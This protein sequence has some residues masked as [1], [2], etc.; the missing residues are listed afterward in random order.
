MRVINL[1]AAT[2]FLSNS[3]RCLLFL[4]ISIKLILRVKLNL[5]YYNQ[6]QRLNG[7]SDFLAV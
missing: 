7:F 4:C 5:F 6:I 1:V 3:F 2:Q